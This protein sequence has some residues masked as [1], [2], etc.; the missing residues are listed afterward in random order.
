[1]PGQVGVDPVTGQAAQQQ[2]DREDG[3]EQGGAEDQY[4]VEEVQCA[5][6]PGQVL[7]C[8]PFVAVSP[9]AGNPFPA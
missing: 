7:C 3:Q 9:A 5:E 1:M 6:S 4:P 8:R 2:D